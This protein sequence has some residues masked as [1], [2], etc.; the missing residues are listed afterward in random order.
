M[1]P[2]RVS[3]GGRIL[4]GS[5]GLPDFGYDG[6]MRQFLERVGSL[7]SD[8]MFGSDD[9]GED[10]LPDLGDAEDAAGDAGLDPSGGRGGGGGN[11]SRGGDL[12]DLGDLGGGLGGAAAGLAGSGLPDVNIDPSVRGS[13]VKNLDL[14]SAWMLPAGAAAGLAGGTMLGIGLSALARGHERRHDE[15]L[16]SMSTGNPIPPRHPAKPASSDPRTVDRRT[17]DDRTRDQRRT[18]R[19]AARR[20]PDLDDDSG[21]ED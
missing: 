18:D 8:E 3:L 7:V 14:G 13:I 4:T 11:G 5:R 20:D 2:A 12:G 19:R 17:S 9:L 10:D 1:L 21:S 15:R 6:G 16:V